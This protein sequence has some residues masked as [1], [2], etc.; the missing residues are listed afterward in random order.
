LSLEEKVRV[1]R[2]I[3]RA[4]GGNKGDV[5]QEILRKFYDQNDLEKQNQNY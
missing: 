1:I 2:E 5:C 3:E 4:G